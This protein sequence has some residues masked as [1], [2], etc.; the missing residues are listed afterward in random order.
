VVEPFSFNFVKLVASKV[1]IILKQP[2]LY[3]LLNSIQCTVWN[4]SPYILCCGDGDT[5]AVGLETTKCCSFLSIW[6]IHLYVFYSSGSLSKDM[7]S[8]KQRVI[9]N[10]HPAVI[11]V[12]IIWSRRDASRWLLVWWQMPIAYSAAKGGDIFRHS[13]TLGLRNMRSQK[14]EDSET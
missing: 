10:K 11:A 3:E 9:H 14:H 7:T 6:G 12:I 4:I 2:A 1:K 13:E 5:A 8:Y